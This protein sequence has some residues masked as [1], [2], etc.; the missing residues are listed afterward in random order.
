MLILFFFFSF[1][2][3]D[4]PPHCLHCTSLERLV[5]EPPSSSSSSSVF[6]FSSLT[7][8]GKT[9]RCKRMAG[10]EN[11]L[12][13]EV[14]WEPNTRRPQRRRLIPILFLRVRPAKSFCLSLCLSFLFLFRK[15]IESVLHIMHEESLY[16]TPPENDSLDDPRP[17]RPSFL[18]SFTWTEEENRFLPSRFLD[19]GD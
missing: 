11:E 4:V 17:D 6:S 12:S 2:S 18:R 15:K 19:G 3:I 9:G 8:E 10:E 16:N 1:S 7:E 14:W 13:G 5:D